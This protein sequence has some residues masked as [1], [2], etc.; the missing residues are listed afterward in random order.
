MRTTDHDDVLIGSN[1]GDAFITLGGADEIVGNNG[2]DYFDPG[3]GDDEIH[4]GEGWDTLG[5]GSATDLE[6][7]GAVATHGIIVNL[8]DEEITRSIDNGLT[9]HTVA[10]GNPSDRGGTVLDAY[11]NTDIFTS[12]ESVGGTDLNDHMSGG[13]NNDYFEG[14]GG[15]DE[16]VGNDGNDQLFGGDGHDFIF[17]NNNEDELFGGA[18]NNSLSGGEGDDYLEGGADGDM[19]EGGNDQ[20]QLKGGDGDDELLGGNG[21]DQLKGGRGADIL[22]G[23][24]GDNSIEYNLETTF[25]GDQGQHGVIVNLSGG[26]IDVVK[27]FLEGSANADLINVGSGRGLDAYIALGGDVSVSTDAITDMIIDVEEIEGTHFADWLVGGDNPD[28]EAQWQWRE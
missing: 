25:T 7:P 28:G 6:L 8:S 22:N 15:N 24:N 14:N 26:S 20:D 11:G 17:G 9:W 12:I 19:L 23:G 3:A 10:A 21:N 1:A 16:L 13:W 27:G 2:D 4:G 18:G 5:Y